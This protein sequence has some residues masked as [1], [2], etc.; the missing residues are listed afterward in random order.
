MPNVAGRPASCREG[1]GGG[2]Q[3]LTLLSEAHKKRRGRPASCREGFGGGPKCLTLLS[4]AHKKRRG[5]PAS[6]REGLEGGPKCLPLLSEK[7]IRR[8]EAGLGQATERPWPAT[9]HLHTCLWKC[10]PPCTGSARQGC[11]PGLGQCLPLLSE[12]PIRRGE[13]GLGRPQCTCTHAFGSA[14][15]PSCTGSARQGC[16]P[17]LSKGAGR[18]LK[19]VQNAYNIAF[20]KAHKK[21]RGRLRTGHREAAANHNAP[22]HMPLEVLGRV[23]L[24][25]A[26]CFTLRCP[27]RLPA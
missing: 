3:C 1:F 2:P 26:N 14:C 10:L 15:L 20:G 23:L 21:R 8:G 4:E 12:K 7:P 5:R 9:M 19:A 6:C 27:R 24:G 25:L 17:G 11:G 18:L 13:A 22:A 16:G